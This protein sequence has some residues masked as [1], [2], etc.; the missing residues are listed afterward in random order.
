MIG[1]YGRTCYRTSIDYYDNI[2]T[3]ILSLHTIPLFI[4]Y[5]RKYNTKVEITNIPILN[6]YIQIMIEGSHIS[7]EN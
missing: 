1:L 4:I 2:I 6:L 5:S 3:L 7:H